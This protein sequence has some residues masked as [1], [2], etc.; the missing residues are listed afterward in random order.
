VK[1]YVTGE[2]TA[3]AQV[4]GRGRST[5]EIL[6]SLQGHAGLALRDG[7][8]S[9]LV[10]E[11]AGLDLAQALGVLFRGDRPLPLRCARLA[12]A[13]EHGVAVPR[14]AVLDN[15]DSTLRI[16]GQVDLRDESLALRV[17]TRPKDISPFTLRTPVTV[18][19]SFAQPVVGVE[20]SRLAG[21]AL[22]AVV[23]GAVAAPAAAVLP[24]IDPGSQAAT[25]PCA[26]VPAAAPAAS[27]AVARKRPP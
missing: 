22:A 27:A 25:D 14:L 2:L 5:A 7:T 13:L 24:F 4:T 16:G 6:G 11:L 1:A 18:G 20:G 17:V 15:A 3:D 10:T 8:L 19:G 26:G 23:L 21:R 9:H 12:L